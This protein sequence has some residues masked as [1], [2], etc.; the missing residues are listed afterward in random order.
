MCVWSEGGE[1]AYGYIVFGRGGVY[2][3]LHVGVCVQLCIYT[4]Y[5]YMC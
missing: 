5:A 4:I 3:H 2:V 1:V